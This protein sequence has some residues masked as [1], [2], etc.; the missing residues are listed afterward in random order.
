M[1][2]I[3][4]DSAAEYGKFNN[5]KE[6]SVVPLT[7]SIDGVDY[8]DGVNLS[9]DKFY[10]L[11]SNSKE[12]ARSSQPNPKRF[13]DAYKPGVD[14]NDQI[15]VITIAS[16]LS[17][18]IGSA[19]VA[20]GLIEYDDI[21]IY[22]SEQATGGERLLVEAALMYAKQGLDA[23]QIMKEL[24]K[25]KE[26]MV[27]LALIDDLSFLVKSGRMSPTEAKI[28]AIAR[29]KPLIQID[30]H[31]VIKV[32]GRPIGKPRAFKTLLKRFDNN[33]IDKNFP[34]F[35]TYTDNPENLNTMLN[36]LEGKLDDCNII[37][38]RFGP[39]VGT[40]I[41]KNGFGIFYFRQD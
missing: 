31:G 20:K 21:H 10:Q 1:V 30:I 36:R 32:I 9:A 4:T 14:A 19:N 18:T 34:V 22:D 8:I 2:R 26:K 25:L 27:Y 13:L 39:T 12:Y 38:G 6:L 23:P 11:V 35:T 3:I 29:I 5:T 33:L 40:H 16:A 37:N 7:I 24:D 15:L 41:G 17:G 28:G